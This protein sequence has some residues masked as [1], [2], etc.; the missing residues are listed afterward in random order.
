MFQILT[1]NTK[2]IKRPTLLTR[3]FLILGTIQ[4]FRQKNSRD[5]N[6]MK[7]NAFYHTGLL[8]VFVVFLHVKYLVEQKKQPIIPV[9]D[10]TLE[11]EACILLFSEKILSQWSQI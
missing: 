1:E 9:V 7:L 5:V 2:T 4:Q 8:L 6:R 3:S 11:M 10:R